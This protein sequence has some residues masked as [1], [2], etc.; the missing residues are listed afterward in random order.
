VSKALTAR[1]LNRAVLVRQMLLERSK[2]SIP[3][4]LERMAGL[5]A[6]YAPAMYVGLWTRLHGCHRDDLTQALIKRTVVQGTLLRATIHLVSAADYWPWAIAIR[7]S[8]RRW[9]LRVQLGKLTEPVM[10]KAAKKIKALLV[11]G[12]KTRKEL[13]QAIGREV[14][15]GVGLWIDMVRVPPS[16][17]W[18][19]RRADLYADAESWIPPR[20]IEPDDARVLLVK[21]YLGGFG[22]STPNELADWSGLSINEV[23]KALQSI[24][25]R[26]FSCEDGKDLF[27]LPRAPRPPAETEAPVRFLHTWDALLLT[28]ARRKQVI[29]EEH[30][31]LVFNTKTPHSVPTFLVD[32]VVAG[33]WRYEG[34][35]VEVSPFE[36]LTRSVKKAVDVEAKR[37]ADFHR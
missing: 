25:S 20:K 35:K 23:N 30:R 3:K 5:Q 4:A 6:Q 31:P 29:K 28:H 17:T 9:W 11:T 33:S 10:K 22:P 7:E 21:R 2:L 18:E 37:L 19:H 13:E 27:D 15:S 16:G 8:R 36:P 1:Q 26:R 34:G 24:E 12:P 32:G 14:W